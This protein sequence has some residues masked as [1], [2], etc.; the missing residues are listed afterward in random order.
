MGRFFYLFRIH[1]L[2]WIFTVWKD[3]TGQENDSRLTQLHLS[4]L[5]FQTFQFQALFPVSFMLSSV[6]RSAQRQMNCQGRSENDNWPVLDF[7][8]WI[9]QD[10]SLG[11]GLMF[12]EAFQYKSQWL[13]GYRYESSWKACKILLWKL[14]KLYFQGCR[15]VKIYLFCEI[16]FTALFFHH[17]IDWWLF[18]SM[19]HS[20][21]YMLSRL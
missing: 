2:M 16:Y 11:S 6:D 3:I 12:I 15:C 4:P 18:S 8:S 10:Y 13:Q 17:W 14:L 20:S 7:Y 19:K 1:S 5:K 21:T 9:C